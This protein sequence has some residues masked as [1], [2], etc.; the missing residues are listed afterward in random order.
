MQYLYTHVW[1]M[2]EKTMKC[3]PKE[4]N[5]NSTIKTQKTKTPNSNINLAV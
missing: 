4:K 3:L 2:Q 5:N 1:D